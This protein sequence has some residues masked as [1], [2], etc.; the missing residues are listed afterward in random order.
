MLG[1]RSSV[2]VIAATLA[3]P[4]VAKAEAPTLQ[5]LIGEPED[6]KL[7]AS[8]RVRYETIDGQARTGFRQDD[9]QLALRSTIFAEYHHA[10]F[11]IGGELFDSR[12]YLDRRN[13]A[14]STS[15]VN[16]FELVQAYVGADLGDVLGAKSTTQLQ[17]GRM[18]LN[19][20][21]RRLVAADDYR[22]TTNGYTGLRA[23]LKTR[24]GTTATLIYTL[25]QMRL[26]DDPASVRRARIK[27]DRESFDLRLWGGLVARPN[28][29]AGATAELSYFRLQE[30]D[31][32][33][34]PNR[35][36]DL[37]TVSMRVIRDPAPERW[38]FEV[39][40]IYQAGAIRAS[41][42]ASAPVLDVD[43]WF[44]H[45][46]LG[47]S[48]EGPARVRLSVEYDYASGDRAGGRYG[49]FD[50]LFGMR[51]ADLAPA[52]LYNAVARANINTPGV[53]VE[54]APGK[55]FDAFAV[56]RPMWLA[57]KTDAFSTTGVRDSL[58]R[59]GSFAGH[60]LEARVR[61]WLVPGFLRG[62]IDAL[63]LARG[64]FLKQAPNARD[65]DTKYLA[66]GVTAT[67]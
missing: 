49:R 27:W 8:V 42:A 41:T 19:L 3:T 29:I 43:A 46:D 60:Q 64:R 52:G 37:H 51:R 1:V 18:M 61:Y 6:F 54:A 44:I 33:G 26:P 14:V 36:R 57:S 4:S 25:P 34:R 67:F 55:R 65:E 20:G 50:T 47:Y 15:E 21:S 31:A 32:P 13:S 17:A 28:T 16:A 56:Y 45:A 30:R 22:N 7:S 58:G 12:V 40:G 53:R 35:N 66:T 48:F 2:L 38:D 5:S 59:S 11:R 62:E 63:W 23:D 24:G 10:G 39:E 9:E